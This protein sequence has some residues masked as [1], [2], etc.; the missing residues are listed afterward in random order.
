MSNSG[1]DIS[2]KAFM[3]F[4]SGRKMDVVFRRRSKSLT[5]LAWLAEECK[6]TGGSIV[7][8]EYKGSG[9]FSVNIFCDLG[10]E[11]EYVIPKHPY[12]NKYWPQ[13]MLICLGNSI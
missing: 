2:T 10:A 12:V 9:R 5:E 6:L 11:I 4:P 7:L 8:A 13:G 3:Y 1:F